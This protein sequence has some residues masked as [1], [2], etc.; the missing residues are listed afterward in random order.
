MSYNKG[1]LVQY[2]LEKAQSTIKEAKVLAV[3][4][5]WSGVVNRLYYSCFYAVI[6][7]LAINEITARTHN[8]VRSAFFKLYIKSG[9]LD[10]KY[11][12]LYSNLMRKRQENDYADFQVFEKE[13]VLPLID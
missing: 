10:K 5:L 3:Q 7:L 13:E 1:D 12:V 9:I 11:S 4:R 6:A 2:R 8:G